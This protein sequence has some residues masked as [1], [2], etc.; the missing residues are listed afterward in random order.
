MKLRKG[1]VAVQVGL[2]ANDH[3]EIGD[4]YFQRFTIP[5]SYFYNPLFLKLLDRASEVY[6]YN[7]NGPLMLPCSIED[8]VN[9]Q[10]R[11]EKRSLC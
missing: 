6:G 4:I 1:F 9:L 2:R 7:A 8:F 11:I 3:D 5:I 10:C